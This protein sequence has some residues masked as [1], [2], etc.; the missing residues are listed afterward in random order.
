MS[1]F[2]YNISITLPC[3]ADSD[4]TDE[5]LV[6]I[7]DANNNPIDNASQ[8]NDNNCKKTKNNNNSNNNNNNNNNNNKNNKKNKNNGNSNNKRIG[9]RK[10]TKKQASLTG[11]KNSKNGRNN[12]NNNNNSN[13]NNNNRN[14]KNVKNTSNKGNKDIHNRNGNQNNKNRNKSKQKGIFFAKEEKKEREREKEVSKEIDYGSHL[15]VIEMKKRGFSND[16]FIYRKLE[17]YNFQID[18]AERHFY[19]DQF[20]HQYCIFNACKNDLNCKGTHSQNF[21]LSYLI[22]KRK[23]DRARMIA[24]YLLYFYCNFCRGQKIDKKRAWIAQLHW[25]LAQIYG[26]HSKSD[27]CHHSKAQQHYLAAIKVCIVDLSIVCLFVCVICLCSCVRGVMFSFIGKK[28]EYYVIVLIFFKQEWVIHEKQ[29][30]IYWK[31]LNF[32]QMQ[33]QIYKWQNF[34]HVKE[35]MM[36]QLY[37]LIE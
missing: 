37:V 36:K 20:C 25:K 22:L 26:K 14:N 6:E 27:D 17:I 18:S 24:E 21:S 16:V 35:D 1:N 31:Q 4:E 11:N 29:N 30:H 15:G 28:D 33:Q 5:P 2:K 12:N 19:Y 10:F 7:S 9:K 13:N 8:Q 23:Y 3:P 34:Y 32:I